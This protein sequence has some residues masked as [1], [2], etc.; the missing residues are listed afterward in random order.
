MVGLSRMISLAARGGIE[1]E[2]IVDQLESTLVC[3]SYAVRTATKRDTSPGSSCPMSIGKALT[4]MY[5]EMQS[6]LHLKYH[7]VNKMGFDGET[8]QLNNTYDKADGANVVNPC[9]ICGLELTFEGGCNTCKS[10][11]YSKCE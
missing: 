9:P 5:E 11:G 3:S 10:C 6:E 4:Q 8:A 1:L 7:G 2:D